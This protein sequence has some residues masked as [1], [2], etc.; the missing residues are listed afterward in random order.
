MAPRE[1]VQ[2][3]APPHESGEGRSAELLRAWIVDDALTVA[4]DPGP[5]RGPNQWGLAFAATVSHLARELAASSGEDAADCQREIFASFVA[6]LV[7]DD[8]SEE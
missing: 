6:A 7:S 8:D 1:R 2:H 4:I 3:L 5:V